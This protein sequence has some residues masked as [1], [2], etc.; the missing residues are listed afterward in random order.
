MKKNEMQTAAESVLN[1]F[2]FPY[3]ILDFP[4]ESNRAGHNIVKIS[5]TLTKEADVYIFNKVLSTLTSEQYEVFSEKLS[6]LKKIGK[7]IILFS[8]NADEIKRFSDYVYLLKNKTVL[9]IT[10]IKSLEQDDII[11]YSL[12]SEYLLSMSLKKKI[13]EYVL[14][15]EGDVRLRTLLDTILYVHFQV[16]TYIQFITDA[17]NINFRYKNCE[18]INEKNK[19]LLQKVIIKKHRQYNQQIQLDDQWVMY[20][21][22]ID[23]EHVLGVVI[24]RESV[25]RVFDSSH[26]LSLCNMITQGFQK[27]EKQAKLVHQQDDLQLAGMF[28]KAVL[29]TDFS[30]IDADTFGI[31]IPAKE[32]GGDFFFVRQL[33]ESRFLFNVC[34][35][36]GKGIASGIVMMLI[37]G[38]F[39]SIN[40][41]EVPSPGELFMQLNNMLY[42]KFE[43][44]KFATGGLGYYD[45]ETGKFIF[46]SAGDEEYIVRGNGEKFT[47]NPD[48]MPLGVM[49]GSEYRDN[50]ISIA[51]GDIITLCTDGISEAMNIRH[52]QYG[53]NKMLSVISDNKEKPVKDIFNIL[54]EDIVAFRGKA[55]QNDDITILMF[56]I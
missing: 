10:S 49:H 27:H 19:Q 5:R 26:F 16:F 44:E 34:D 7:V 9:P 45:R 36:S 1:E 54:N 14:Q 51:Q 37:Q 29:M 33:T 56:K 23:E 22:K 3:G 4:E 8:D 31:S 17:K 48:G 35:V 46:T 21:K 11:E 47:I 52:E 43:G 24:P 39:Q 18:Y 38:F 15:R 2:Q 32:L 41:N 40:A 50:E 13:D 25:N 30:G 6:R 53:E 55:D 12:P 28:Q 20:T 42:D